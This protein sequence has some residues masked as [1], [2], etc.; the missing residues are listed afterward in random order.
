MLVAHISDLHLGRTWPGDQVDAERLNSLR[1]ALHTLAACNPD[2]LIVAGDT[3]DGVNID[4]AIV[5]E[6]AKSLGNVKN[7][8]GQAIPVVIIP[9]NHDPA[10]AD[11]LWSAF[12]KS[13]GP[14]STVRLALTPTV[15]ELVEGKLLVEAY[16]CPTRFSAA[17]P[18]DSRLPMPARADGVLRVVVAHGT[19]QGGPV[20]EGEGDAYPFSQ[21][22][23][24]A[25]GADY[26]ALGHFHGVYPPWTADDECQRTVCYCGTHEPDQHGGDTGFAILATL[27]SGQPT[28]LRRLRVARRTWHALAVGG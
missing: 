24:E 10:D 12:Q 25:L 27:S 4:P 20:P 8:G 11:K 14:S 7:D 28:R 19:L 23:V 5:D 3:F 6:A 22:A 9:G 18:W 17:A 2:V 26:V 21:A 16:P 15:I 1:Q 13:L